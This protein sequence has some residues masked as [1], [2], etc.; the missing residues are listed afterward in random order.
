M[1]ELKTWQ[2]VHQDH[3]LT[4]FT[5]PDSRYSNQTHHFDMKK[6]ESNFLRKMKLQKEHL[7]G[8]TT[9]QS[10]QSAMSYLLPKRILPRPNRFNQKSGSVSHGMN[11]SI[12]L[13]NDDSQYENLHAITDRGR[14]DSRS[15][16]R[17]ARKEMG[18]P[19]TSAAQSNPHMGKK[20]GFNDQHQGN[21]QNQMSNSR[22]K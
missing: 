22:F 13:I 16:I 20:S 1:E 4:Q 7:A 11:P 18:Q 8:K 6:R 9:N 17:G 12:L 5:S 15:I 3:D 19:V 14:V 2:R 21:S 10:N